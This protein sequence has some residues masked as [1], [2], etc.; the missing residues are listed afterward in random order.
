MSI[1]ELKRKYPEL[2]NLPQEKKEPKLSE[3]PP[4]PKKVKPKKEKKESKVTKLK[5]SKSKKKVVDM[6]DINEEQIIANHIKKSKKMIKMDTRKQYL[7]VLVGFF[8]T[9]YIL[10]LLL[11]NVIVP[12]IVHSRPMVEVPSVIGME[13]EDARARLLLKNIDFEVVSEQYSTEYKPG[14]VIKQTP[15]EGAMVKENR[16]VYLTVSRGNRLVRVPKIIGMAYRKAEITLLNCHLEVGKVDSVSSEVYAPNTVIGQIPKFNAEKKIGSKVNVTISIGSKNTVVVPDL[17]GFSL[18]GVYQ[19]IQNSG[20]GLG[21]V[22][23]EI[24]ELYDSRT[25]ISQ[26]PAAGDTIQKGSKINL[27]VAQ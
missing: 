9:L 13:E 8:A 12:K 19:Y 21:N 7:L 26:I 25:I 6:N 1:E 24:N 14:I 20:L 18:E 22:V 4:K 11:N 23:Y 16:P 17:V 27:T 10:F 15:S 5:N 3:K 2:Y